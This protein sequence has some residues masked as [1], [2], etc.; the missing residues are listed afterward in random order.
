MC[1]FWVWVGSPCMDEQPQVS[2]LLNLLLFHRSIS[3][4]ETCDLWIVNLSQGHY[5]VLQQLCNKVEPGEYS[6]DMREWNW[7]W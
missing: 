7:S 2:G 4:F 5:R 1:A 3:H 6:L